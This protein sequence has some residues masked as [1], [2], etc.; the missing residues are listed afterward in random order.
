MQ[1]QFISPESELLASLC[2]N[3]PITGDVAQ[4][5]PVFLKHHHHAKTALHCQQVAA[6]AERIAIYAGVDSKK[7]EMAGLLH[8]VSVILPVPERATIAR[9]LGIEVL[10]EEEYCPMIVHQKLSRLMASNIFGVTDPLILD[11]VG[12]HTTLRAHSTEL[13]KVLFVA[14]KLAWDH[15]GTPPYDRGLR[16]A[17]E[18]SLDQA[19]RFLVNYLWENRQSLLVI[20][21]WLR[22]AYEDLFAS[23]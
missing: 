17:L 15:E 9:G 2:L 1:N 3:V 22:E 10:E 18:G 21:P 6:E 20:H 19:A 16:D 23:S 7:A 14:D 11:A 4:D 8:D 12:C 5:V 13:D